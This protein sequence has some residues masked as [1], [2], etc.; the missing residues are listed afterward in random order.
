MTIKRIYS[1]RPSK[2]FKSNAL[3]LRCGIN[4]LKVST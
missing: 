1:K 4:D 3:K 2:G